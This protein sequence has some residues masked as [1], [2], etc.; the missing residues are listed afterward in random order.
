M[1]EDACTHCV[2]PMAGCT[3]RSHSRYRPGI[4]GGDAHLPEEAHCS[5]SL[6]VALA[7]IQQ[8][9]GVLSC[10]LGAPLPPKQRQQHSSCQALGRIALPVLLVLLQPSREAACMGN[11]VQNTNAA[12]PRMLTVTKPAA[13]LPCKTSKQS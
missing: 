4:R 2:H 10:L 8:R 9:V 3:G 13:A 1:R 11:S 12:A 7:C 6:L 5:A